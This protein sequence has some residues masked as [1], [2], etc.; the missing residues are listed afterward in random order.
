M[1]KKAVLLLAGLLLILGMSA[2]A[3]AGP[4]QDVPADHWAYDAVAKLVAA[5]LVEGFPDGTF[6]GDRTMNRYQFA[7]IIA[8]M[9][10]KLDR[11]VKD[12]VQTENAAAL[13]A[14]KDARD[15]AA[16]A[17][18]AAKTAKDAEAMKAATAAME[19]AEAAFQAAQAAM[20]KAE[21]ASSEAGGA[22][23]AAGSAKT[24]ADSAQAAADSAQAAA[25]SAAQL[26][27]EALA[28]AQKAAGVKPTEVV[29]LIE[30]SSPPVD[31]TPLEKAIKK[32]GEEKAS[33]QA[34]VGVMSD[35]DLAVATAEELL[36]RMDAAE[37]AIGQLQEM[38]GDVGTLQGDVGE[39]QGDVDLLKPQVA[40]LQ[41]D[42]KARQEAEAATLAKVADVE[43]TIKDLLVEFK[44]D[45]ANQN[46][47]ISTIQDL[48]DQLGGRV[49]ALEDEVA[50][51]KTATV[52]LDEKTTALDEKTTAL[53]GRTTALEGKTAGLATDVADLKN[54]TTAVETKTA[55]IEQKLDKFIAEHEKLA[56][57]GSTSVVFTDGKRLGGDATAVMYADPINDY[58]NGSN[59]IKNE[60]TFQQKLSLGMVATPAAGVVAKG[61]I[62]VVNNMFTDSRDSNPAQNPIKDSLGLS[63]SDLY[64]DITTPGALKSLYF[65]KIDAG[66][67]AEGFPKAVFSANGFGYNPDP[68]PTDPSNTASTEN[69]REGGTMMLGTGPVT[70]KVIMSRFVLDAHVNSDGSTT[71]A[72]AEY[73]YAMRSAL[74][75]GDPANIG[76]SYV[77]DRTRGYDAA[78]TTQNEAFAVDL[79]GKFGSFSYGGAY[80]YDKGSKDSAAEASGSAKL[81][82]ATLGVNFLRNGPN[83][84]ARF[85]EPWA[86]DAD[87]YGSSASASADWNKDTTKTAATVSMPVWLVT[88]SGEYGLKNKVS[89]PTDGRT[90]QK[91]QVEMALLGGTVKSYV[92]NTNYTGAEVVSGNPR[93]LQVYAGLEK[94]KLFNLLTF[95]TY[96]DRTVQAD[97]TQK[98]FVRWADAAMPFTFIGMPMEL[99]AEYGIKYH[100]TPAVDRTH[101]KGTFGIKDWKLGERITVNASVIRDQHPIDGN[102]D[103]TADANVLKAGGSLGVLLFKELKATGSAWLAN[104]ST[105][106]GAVASTARSYGLDIT[107]PV[108]GVD[109]GAGVKY[110][111]YDSA[112]DN[113]KDYK[114]LKLNAG[115]SYSF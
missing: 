7:Q 32:L 43:R 59:V 114:A 37:G 69:T 97:N 31:L 48:I 76:V 91:G 35:A 34:L 40:N 19:R 33:N 47:K 115:L 104:T 36:G 52:A 50:Q 113:T 106:A 73:A 58:G 81:G 28:M 85:K 11:L 57:T 109:L 67:A 13:K 53:D 111:E 112:T 60:S 105:D 2:P 39:L 63:L 80:A 65:G 17:L 107:Y 56:F 42:M 5:G 45:L 72:S 101:V 44:D 110:V 94:A 99:A 27:Q 82:P 87:F 78:D 92:K 100:A 70:T 22:A 4:F 54:R 79:S 18:D 88:L 3:T 25:D 10:D 14:A 90:W 20:D 21:A 83:Y 102:G 84:E 23:S 55:S 66:K 103:Y 98:A 46:A 68:D 64:L 61:S 71:P 15:L 29:K 1:G 26:A 93:D 41:E 108:V 51:L 95:T 62:S 8:R 6:K 12:E 30:K 86:G 89:T 77:A 96:I 24:A 74:A 9:V 16:Q 75:I 49:T 38:Q